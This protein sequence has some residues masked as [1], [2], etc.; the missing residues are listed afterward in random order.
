VS[1]QKSVEIINGNLVTH[2]G[3]IISLNN[4]LEQLI[5]FEL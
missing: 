4:S 1:V 5:G 3:L 2:T